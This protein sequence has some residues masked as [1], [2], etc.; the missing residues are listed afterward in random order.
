MDPQVLQQLHDIQLPDP[1]GW[2]PMAFAWWILLLS[3]TSIIIGII[4]Y[5]TDQ[6]RRNVYRRQAQKSLQQIMQKQASDDNKIMQIN[7]L[8]KQVAVT[9][10]GR[11]RVAALHQNQWLEFLQDNASYIPQPDVIKQYSQLAYAPPSSQNAELTDAWH[12]YAQ[13]WIKGHHQ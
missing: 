4:W 9:A 12:D 5:F 6:R 11:R 2:W 3:V 10:Y 13:R 1:I 8:L 7:A